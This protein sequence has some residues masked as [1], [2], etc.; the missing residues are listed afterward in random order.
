MFLKKIPKASSFAAFMLEHFLLGFFITG[1]GKVNEYLK[2]QMKEVF[3]NKFHWG[4]KFPLMLTNF[5]HNL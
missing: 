4:E 1:L 3:G 2:A 5:S